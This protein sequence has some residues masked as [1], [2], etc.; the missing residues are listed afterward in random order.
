MATSSKWN[1][2]RQDIQIAAKDEREL[3]LEHDS[4]P[5]EDM[6]FNRPNTSTVEPSSTKAD[7]KMDSVRLQIQE[8]T[9]V[10]RNNVQKVMERGDRLEELQE[11]SDR[12]SMAGDEFRAAAKRA[13]QKAWLQNF[14]TRII[15]VT[16]T[17]TV[18]I[19]IIGT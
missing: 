1:L 13:Q 3:L 8:V 14:K 11:A 7:G 10:M 18:V 2:S 5:D 6:L 12:L 16:I 17:M 15:L 9:D 19:C 4:D